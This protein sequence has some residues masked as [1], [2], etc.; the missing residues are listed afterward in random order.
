[1]LPV[2]VSLTCHTVIKRCFSYDCAMR[3]VQ[4]YRGE[5]RAPLK[6]EKVGNGSVVP[7]LEF[8]VDVD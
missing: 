7:V 5:R 4:G 6:H 1:M 2:H 8:V 3:T